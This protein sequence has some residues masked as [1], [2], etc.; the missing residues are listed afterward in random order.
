LVASE[1]Q[2]SFSPD[3]RPFQTRS[4]ECFPFSRF[5]QAI[6]KTFSPASVVKKAIFL[7]FGMS[8]TEGTR[9]FFFLSLWIWWTSSKEPP[10]RHPVSPFFVYDRD[11]LFCPTTFFSLSSD[12]GIEPDLPLFMK[13]QLF[14]SLFSWPFSGLLSLS[15]AMNEDLWSC[16]VLKFA[17]NLFSPSSSRKI[18]AFFL[19]QPALSPSDASHGGE[20]FPPSIFF[21]NRAP[22]STRRAKVV[23][24]LPPRK[25]F[26]SPAAACFLHFMRRETS[27]ARPIGPS[28]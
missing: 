24:P 13:L 19:P 5:S 23:S 14:F 11:F 3:S 10:P 25:V 9:S 20:F 27:T 26:L 1:G 18:A 15:V 2:P 6:R 21:L 22:S 16:A 7:F 4:D 28:L 8:S 12:F 17:K